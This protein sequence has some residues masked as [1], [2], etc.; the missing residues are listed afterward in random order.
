MLFSSRR[1]FHLVAQFRGFTLF[2]LLFDG[3]GSTEFAEVRALRERKRNAFTLVEL[4]VVI[5]I[6]GILVALLLPAIQAA[7]EAARR[8]A[9]QN[10]LHNLALA[11]MNYE[12]RQNAFPP[13]VPAKISAG[14]LVDLNEVDQKSSWIV[15]ILPE[16][17]EQALYDRFDVTKN[18]FAYTPEIWPGKEPVQSLFCPSDSARDRF[19]VT[20][21]R[22]FAKGNYAAYV[23]PEHV[24]RMRV[25]PG[26]MI[27]EPQPVSRLDDGM[28]KTL[29]LSE[30]R[31]R[32]FDGDTRGVW[33]T[34][35]VGGSTLA[36]DM[37]SK[38]V[39]EPNAQ[40][41]KRRTPYDPFVYLSTPG[42]VPNTTLGYANEDYIRGCPDP[43]KPAAGV[44]G[45]PCHAHTSTRQ[46]ASP[47]SLHPGGVNAAN[48]DGSVIFLNDEIEMHLM[49][50]LISINDGQGDREGEFKP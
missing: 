18:Y 14:E 48:A 43:E 19:Y 21:S 31:T 42:L 49:A 8:V 4:L 25:Y 33:A 32:A 22:N 35:T 11:V 29:M 12:N 27:N 6:I 41:G 36:F 10:N 46:A 9:C 20:S 28:S 34:G 2:E 38:T 24:V 7:R 13:A 44:E 5:A 40:T 45:M 15:H 3:P 1:L 30:V 47:R 23:S 50:R 37:H 39:P 26:A 16:I 17:E